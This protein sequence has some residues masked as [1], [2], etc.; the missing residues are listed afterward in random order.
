MAEQGFE[1]VRYA[2][3]FVI[4]CRSPEDAES[5]GPGATMDGGS[6]SDAASGEDQ[7]RR[8][9][10]RRALTFSAIGSSG[11]D[12]SRDRR[13]SRSSKTRSAEDQTDLWGVLEED[14]HRINPCCEAG[15]VTSNIAIAKVHA[16]DGWIRMRLRSILRKRQG[17]QGRGRGSDHHR[18]PNTFFANMGCTA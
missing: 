4:L 8:R 7:D 13:A 17:K 1:M 9:N 6:R 12:D 16:L 11:D 5:L 15:S 14:H 10:D 3:D 18:W 2:D